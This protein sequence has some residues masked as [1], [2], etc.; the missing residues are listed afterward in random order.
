MRRPGSVI[1][2]P[3]RSFKFYFWIWLSSQVS[4]SVTRRIAWIGD[5][6]CDW[7]VKEYGIVYPRPNLP[8]NP[9]WR[10]VASAVAIIHFLHVV[11]IING[12]SIKWLAIFSMKVNR[13]SWMLIQ[14][15][16]RILL[17]LEW[18]LKNAMDCRE[19][20][21]N[22][23]RLELNFWRLSFSGE[24]VRGC[25][26]AVNP[27]PVDNCTE[28]SCYCHSEKCNS[29]SNLHYTA[30]LFIMALLATVVNL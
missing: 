25:L 18:Y 5:C 4:T 15:I 30:G 23:K 20:I 2:W 17:F 14:M 26:S 16:R 9:H 13:C 29:A 21:I 11:H 12:W 27:R 3:I 22:L 6:R 7:G 28:T 1:M 19:L 10:Y 24:T 8:K